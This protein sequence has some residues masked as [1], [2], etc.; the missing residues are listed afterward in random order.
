MQN[1]LPFYGTV[2]PAGPFWPPKAAS[3]QSTVFHTDLRWFLPSPPPAE[4]AP[5]WDPPTR[6]PAAFHRLP[7]SPLLRF[8]PLPPTPVVPTAS[9]S[10]QSTPPVF[11]L[12]RCADASTFFH[13]HPAYTDTRPVHLTR[14]VTR[15]SLRGSMET[16]PNP[17]QSRACPRCPRTVHFTL[18]WTGICTAPGTLMANHAR[19]SEAG[20]CAQLLGH[21]QPPSRVVWIRVP[22]SNAR[23]P[24]HTCAVV[25]R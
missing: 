23:G 11:L 12:H 17:R 19:A 14:K 4:C 21:C 3:S 18:P 20:V 16:T 25:I 6:F 5:R 2:F 24:V 13:R 9:F 7:P 15:Q 1:K 8:H 10:L 22:T